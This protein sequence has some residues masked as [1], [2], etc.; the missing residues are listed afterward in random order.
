M[1]AVV[2]SD[3]TA[4]AARGGRAN[5]TATIGAIVAEPSSLGYRRED[6]IVFARLE[7]DR[8]RDHLLLADLGEAA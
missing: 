1:I 5:V 2:V 6:A 8:P 3:P 7:D 4:G